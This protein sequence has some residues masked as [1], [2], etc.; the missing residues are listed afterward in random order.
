M[1]SIIKATISHIPLLVDIGKVS[2]IESHGSSASP[3]VIDE[4]V[5]KT[6]TYEVFERELNNDENIYHIIYHHDKPAGYSKIIFNKPYTEFGDR[7]ITKLERL[8]LVK[9]F[10]GLQLG[11]KLLNFNIQ[12]SQMNQQQGM[13]LFVWTENQ[14]AVNFYLNMGFQIVG[15]HDFKLTEA[16]ANPNHQM[17]L[18]Y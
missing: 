6:Y 15:S 7:L 8:Y 2:F 3:K 10:Y 16:H 1:T 17:Y 12:L 13:S 5:N 4:Y 9:E 18:K 11:Q 14:R